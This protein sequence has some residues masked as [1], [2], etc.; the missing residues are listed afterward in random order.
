MDSL[1]D[2]SQFGYRIVNTLGKNH[3]GGRTTYLATEVNSNNN[4]VIKQFQ[5]ASSNSDWLGYK[6][7]QR[8]I[9]ILEQLEHSGIP[10]YL[11]SFETIDGFC[12][13]QEYKKAPSLAIS[14]NY[15]PEE[16][17]GIAIAILEILI[18]LQNRLPTVIHRDL[19]PE[20]ILV[21]EQGKV[22]LVDFGFA[23]LGSE[24]LA[25]SSVTLGTLGFMPPEQLY[26]RQ[27]TPATDLYSLGMTLIC[28][29]T[30]IKSS[31]IDTLID[32]DNNISFQYLLLQLSQRWLNWLQTLVQRNPNHRYKNAVQALEQLK[33]IYIFKQ[34]ETKLSTSHLEFTANTYGEKLTKTITVTNF[35]AETIL[36]GD[37]QVASHPSDP[38]HTPDSHA[39]ITFS[40][41]KFVSNKVE[42]KITVDSSQLLADSNYQ[43]EIL[44]QTNSY[45]ET[46]VIN[47]NVQTAKIVTAKIPYLKLFVSILLTSISYFLFLFLLGENND[48]T[49]VFL[50]LGLLIGSIFMLLTGNKRGMS[51]K[52]ILW[53]GIRGFLLTGGLVTGLIYGQKYMNQ[54]TTLSMVIAGVLGATIPILTLNTI[55]R[56]R[57]DLQKEKLNNFSI[58]SI[59]S[60][61]IFLGCSISEYLN[62]Y[63][64]SRYSFIRS[65]LARSFTRGFNDVS[66]ILLWKI[67]IASSALLA[68]VSHHSFKSFI[69]SKKYRQSKPK[70]IKP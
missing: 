29:L 9:S 16:I 66:D 4:V 67:G 69:I 32:E 51:W 60:I 24:N 34:P 10:Q 62:S 50:L 13:V 45:P 38:P 23:R 43:R 27:L 28:L 37:W 30:R 64:D 17:K 19:K 35:I 25:M 70:L 39:W 5:F 1:P 2:F 61:V 20:N 53:G 40:E 41:S 56:T 52:K 15:E 21:D 48:F 33:P 59:L 26:N 65:F 58:Y 55:A 31:E 36:E 44:L 3:F 18:Y 68:L 42:L 47:I 22:Y 49:V 63:G 54:N 46:Q 14:R 57:L 12:M 11:A 6:A 7:Y 8:E